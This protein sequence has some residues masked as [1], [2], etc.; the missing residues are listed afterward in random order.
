MGAEVGTER[1]AAP[2]PQHDAR[3]VAGVM[4]VALM[5]SCTTASPNFTTF[6]A[7][8]AVNAL[9]VVVSQNCAQSSY[10]CRRVT[11]RVHGAHPVLGRAGPWCAADTRVSA[12]TRVTV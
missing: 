4:M 3:C 2:R 6:L 5:G 1:S 10:G 8:K 11:L 12:Q 9:F 7:L